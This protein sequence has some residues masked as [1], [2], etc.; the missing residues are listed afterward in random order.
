MVRVIIAAGWWD[1]G[2]VVSAICLA[3]LSTMTVYQFLIRKR[4]HHLKN[5]NYKSLFSQSS[6]L[7]S[8]TH[9]LFFNLLH[10]VI[11]KILINDSKK[12]VFKIKYVNNLS[13]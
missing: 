6:L 9:I 10:W 1:N 7:P 4:N 11:M 12:V 8:T 5:K 3:E 2:I 13:P